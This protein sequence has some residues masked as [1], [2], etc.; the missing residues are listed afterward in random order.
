MVRSGDLNL[1]GDDLC[2]DLYGDPLLESVGM[3]LDKHLQEGQLDIHF[4]EGQL[5]IHLEP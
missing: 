1:H 4:Q 2:G 5:D 3:D